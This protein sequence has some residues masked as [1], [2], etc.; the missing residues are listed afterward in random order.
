MKF[1]ATEPFW[2]AYAK[3]PPAVKEKA[4]EAFRLF[5]AGAAS[6]PF[7]PS[8]RIRKMQG[9][10]NIWEGHITLQ[11]VFNFMLTVTLTPENKPLFSVMWARTKSTGDLN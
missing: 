8:L 1:H 5:K 7:H 10:P 3:L 9:H 11:Y 4:R 6:P 2:E